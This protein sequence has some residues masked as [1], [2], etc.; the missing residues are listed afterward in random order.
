[1]LKIN[2]KKV[3]RNIRGIPVMSGDHVI[4]FVTFCFVYWVVCLLAVRLFSL[5]LF[6]RAIRLFTLPTLP[7]RW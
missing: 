5:L 1:M 4:V 2:P 6:T 3:S 7:S